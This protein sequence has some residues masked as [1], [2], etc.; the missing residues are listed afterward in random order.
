MGSGR[1]SGRLSED[2][3]CMALSD[4]GAR[5]DTSIKEREFMSGFKEIA[6]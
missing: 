6:P 4:K 5:G 3:S 1:S 2:G